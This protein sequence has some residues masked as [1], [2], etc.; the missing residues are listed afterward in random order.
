MA[1]FCTIARQILKNDNRWKAYI[2]KKG[3]RGY[4][5]K[6]NKILKNFII[7]FE[8]E[9][10][11]QDDIGQTKNFF[12]FKKI[13]FPKTTPPFY[14]IFLSG[15]QYTKSIADRQKK[16]RPTVASYPRKKGGV[17]FNT[18]QQSNKHTHTIKH[19]HTRRQRHANN[20]NTMCIIIKK[21]L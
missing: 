17:V 15:T 7:V 5:V 16:R 4:R 1:Y 2:F 3:K 14:I 18:P 19:T 8:N 11:F 13:F 21:T 9:N 10:E 12:S 6:E 20:T